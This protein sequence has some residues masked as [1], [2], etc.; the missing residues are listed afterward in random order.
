MAGEAFISFPF[1][2]YMKYWVRCL[3]GG[4]AICAFNVANYPM[5]VELPYLNEL[6]TAVLGP[7][8]SIIISFLQHFI[9]GNNIGEGLHCMATM[10]NFPLGLFLASTCCPGTPRR[11]LRNRSRTYK[12]LGTPSPPGGLLL[13]SSS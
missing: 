12:S 13:M 6:P 11:S 8:V 1:G 9:A 4:K 10:R 5:L 7:L 2:L 3:S